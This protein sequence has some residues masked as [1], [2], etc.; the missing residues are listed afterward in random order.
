VIIPLDRIQVDVGDVQIHVENH[1]TA[2]GISGS[3]A[4]TYNPDEHKAKP[5]GPSGNDVFWLDV[6]IPLTAEQY[7]TL[8]NT[9]AVP[10]AT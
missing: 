1:E 5:L 3:L 7:Q 4:G 9:F 6:R 8:V 10:R 2:T